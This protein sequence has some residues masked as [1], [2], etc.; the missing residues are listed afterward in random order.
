MLALLGTGGR[1]SGRNL[2]LLDDAI[3]TIVNVEKIVFS[4]E[5][6]SHLKGMLLHLVEDMVADSPVPS[7]MSEYNPRYIVVDPVTQHSVKNRVG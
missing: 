3:E 4:I 1:V 2:G 6:G 7:L 5:I